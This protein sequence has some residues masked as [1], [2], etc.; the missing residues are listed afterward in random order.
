MRSRISKWVI[1]GVLTILLGTVAVQLTKS[2]VEDDLTNRSQTALQS[3]GMNWAKVRF[4]GRD[5]H[6]SGISTEQGQ[7]ERATELIAAVHGVR[8]VDHTV[9]IAPAASPYPF[10]AK[11]SGGAVSLSGGIPDEAA[12]KSIL[13]IAKPAETDLELMSGVKDRAK[14]LAATEFALRQLRLFEQGEVRLN[15]MTLSMSG[16]SKSRSAFDTISIMLNAGFPNGLQKGDIQVTPPLQSPFEWKAEFDGKRI[17][18]R[19]YVPNSEAIEQIGKAVPVG[20]VMTPDILLASGAP[21]S[22]S[23][24]AATLIGAFSKV[25]AG[26]A[27]IANSK[28]SFTGDPVSVDAVAQIEKTFS[29]TGAEITL[30]LPL[31]EP[32]VL[33][34]VKSADGVTFS[35]FVPDEALLQRLSKSGNTQDV[36]LAR[37]APENFAAAIEFVTA[38]IA[39]LETG[40]FSISD[41]KI[42]ISGKAPDAEAYQTAQTVLQIGPPKGF[43]LSK[44][45]L[46]PM[47]SPPVTMPPLPALELLKNPPAMPVARPAAPEA[48]PAPVAPEPKIVTPELPNL[49]ALR[50][51][52]STPTPVASPSEMIAKMDAP[53]TTPPA[54]VASPKF[55]TPELP[56]LDALKNPP[57]AP[58]I[59]ASLPTQTEPAQTE[60]APQAPKLALCRAHIADF[61]TENSILFNAGSAKLLDESTEPLDRLASSLRECPRVEIHVEGHTD[62]DG[63]ENTNM[64]L[65]VARAEAVV[66][67]LIARGIDA[68]RLYAVGYGEGKPVADNNTRAGKAQN[69]RIAFEILETAE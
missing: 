42:E 69:R 23:A 32:F 29:S 54:S 64:A 1:P 27:T 66:D 68:G 53:V 45:A 37:T 40:N 19:G 14:W 21:D 35:G 65:S 34:G 24:N 4:D 22:F 25:S 46:E 2:G 48:K 51:P 7:P 8:S 5:A 16:L 10:F 36:A 61:E 39:P 11:I 63:P 56:N 15:D 60:P 62:S 31:V 17:T 18:M 59:V 50:E 28:L 3:A 9:E 55:M 44:N 20:I 12:R 52:P 6:L 57:P 58:A 49:D 33:S 13:E 67:Q 47:A 41:T 43:D 30:S 26:V 38:A